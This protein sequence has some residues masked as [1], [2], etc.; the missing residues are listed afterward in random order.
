[1]PILLLFIVVPII[2]I[3]LFIQVGGWL[4]LWPTILIVILTAIIGTTLLR[5][6]GM[7]A[8]QR[9]NENLNTGRNPVDPI[10]HG[11]MI[12]AAGLLLLTPGFF[13][14]AVGFALLVPGIRS[15][16]ISWG[17]ARMVGRGTVVFTN[18]GQESGNTQRHNPRES[19]A[20]EGDFVV[21]D[22]DDENPSP[23]NSGWTKG[24]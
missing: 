12:L 2:E 3:A 22:E 10:V 17:A 18:T 7:A 9:L 6:Q 1:M 24:Q 23:G 20:V 4:G 19:G 5:I 21:L 8:L 11:A 14:D 16:L 15:M 13:T